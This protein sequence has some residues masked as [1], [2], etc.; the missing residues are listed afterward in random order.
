MT[1]TQSV[2]TC[3]SK[4]FNYQ[5]RAKRS[6]YWYFVLFTWIISFVAGFLEGIFLANNYSYGSISNFLTL[7]LIIPTINVATRRL[8]DVNRSGWWQLLYLTIIGGFVILYW[9][10]KKGI[11][12]SN[13][14]N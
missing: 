3:F 8:H 6:E 4:F 12:E 10:V 1:F 13:R 5:G 11:D 14:F 2:K 7:I 9:T